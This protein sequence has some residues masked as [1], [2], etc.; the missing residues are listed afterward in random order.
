MALTDDRTLSYDWSSRHLNYEQREGGW[1][2]WVALNVSD[3]CH[4][5]FCN[6]C[7]TKLGL[8]IVQSVEKRS[9]MCHTLPIGLDDAFCCLYCSLSGYVGQ[10]RF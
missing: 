8:F 3:V 2:Y 9:Y 6:I 7:D 4:A 10:I 5:F 1:T